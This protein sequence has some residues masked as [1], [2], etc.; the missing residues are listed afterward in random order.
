MRD[1][2]SDFDTGGGSSRHRGLLNLKQNAIVLCQNK[3]KGGI[4][5]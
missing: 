2:L 1:D 4:L 3:I 5:S